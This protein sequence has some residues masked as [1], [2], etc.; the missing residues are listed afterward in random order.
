MITKE[1]IE[2]GAR[3]GDVPDHKA[4][5]IITAAFAAMSE[6]VAWR[7][8]YQG[9]KWT[10]QKNKPHW[11]KDG[12]ADVELE[13]LYAAPQPAQDLASENERMRATAMRMQVAVAKVLEYGGTE[14][15]IW[16]DGLAEAQRNLARETK[17]TRSDFDALRAALERT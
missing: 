5:Q 2:A 3:A 8:R 16:F 14:I 9:G 12:M 17:C 6:P 10:V 11:Y 7:Y 4:E 15:S 1:A 13:P